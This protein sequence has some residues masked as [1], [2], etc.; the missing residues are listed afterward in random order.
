MVEVHYKKTKSGD[1]LK[2]LK[3]E[4]SLTYDTIDRLFWDSDGSKSASYV[5]AS[6]KNR[7]ALIRRLK[8]F[9]HPLVTTDEGVRWGG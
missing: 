8:K 2:K 9:G 7:N 3:E 6:I 5:D 1:F 4:K